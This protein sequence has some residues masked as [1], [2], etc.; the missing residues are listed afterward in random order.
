M[1]ELE[2]LKK[3][4]TI[5]EREWSF[6]EE[7]GTSQRET[8]IANLLAYFFNPSKPHG[9]DDTFIKALLKTEP[10]NL[11]N[12][13]PAK[14]PKSIS[15]I[16]CEGFSWA[17][18][19]IEDS[20]QKNNRIDIVIETEK[21]MIAIEFKINH[22]LNNPLDNYVSRIKEYKRDNNYYIVLTPYWKKPG[23]IAKDN[24]EFVQ[25]IIGDFINN[26]LKERNLIQYQSKEQEVFFDDFITTI[27]NRDRTLRMINEYKEFAEVNNNMDLL[28]SF[29]TNLNTIKE[30]IEGKA[31]NLANQLNKEF[32]N[33]FSILPYSKDRLESVIVTT[34][35]NGEELKIRFTLKGRTVELWGIVDGAIKEIE[36]TP[37]KDNFPNSELT[38]Q[39]I[40]DILKECLP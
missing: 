40:K 39:E 14:I 34:L 11:D 36:S 24:K 21:L 31:K 5:E 28:E 35:E 4:P 13:N 16:A 2:L 30:H 1:D 7:I 33:R 12:S 8:I 38:F 10:K 19:H 23:D 20:T 27:K 22:H 32:H 26:L 18:I 25:V 3:L 37:K 6:L 29:F 17:K 15:E 9:L